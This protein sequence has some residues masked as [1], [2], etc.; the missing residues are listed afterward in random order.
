MSQEIHLHL[1]RYG[2]CYS[3]MIGIYIYRLFFTMDIFLNAGVILAGIQNL[4]EEK[5]DEHE[6][7]LFLVSRRR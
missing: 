1:L 7:H 4:T 5:R 3:D 6:N 2:N